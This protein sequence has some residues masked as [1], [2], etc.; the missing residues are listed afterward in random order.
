MMLVTIMAKRKRVS[1]RKK[2]VLRRLV[3]FALIAAAASVLFYAFDNHR[4]AKAKLIRALEEQIAVTA[5]GGESYFTEYPVLRIESKK[6]MELILETV[7]ELKPI[8][9]WFG[10]IHERYEFSIVTIDVRI[11]YSEVQ[12]TISIDGTRFHVSDNCAADLK[13]LIRAC[14]TEYRED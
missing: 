5:E 11:V 6:D 10:I 4:I 9:I 14:W 2:R 1:M 8:R 12:C 7:K 3:T 13:E